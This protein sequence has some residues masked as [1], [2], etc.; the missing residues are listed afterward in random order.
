M[1]IKDAIK[2]VNSDIINFISKFKPKLVL[3]VVVMF[4]LVVW[5][6]WWS[7]CLYYLDRYGDIHGFF[8]TP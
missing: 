5:G 4:I 8:E 1:K 7:V 2:E 6:C 3:Q